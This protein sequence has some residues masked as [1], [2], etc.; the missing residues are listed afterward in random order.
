[1]EINNITEPAPND[2][3]LTQK[4][5]DQIESDADTYL[6]GKVLLGIRRWSENRME[7]WIK[8]DVRT[9]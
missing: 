6:V 3:A 8:K 7:C 9:K 1:M 4:E 2:Y 5:L